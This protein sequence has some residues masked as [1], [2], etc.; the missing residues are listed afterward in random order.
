MVMMRQVLQKFS[1]VI[2]VPVVVVG[3]LGMAIQAQEQKTTD[4]SWSDPEVVGVSGWSIDVGVDTSGNAYVVWGDG[5]TIYFRIRSADGTWHSVEQ[6]ATHSSVLQETAGVNANDA[7][8]APTWVNGLPKV[9]VDSLGQAYVAWITYTPHPD[10]RF[11][12]YFR[13]R[14]AGGTWGPVQQVVGDSVAD[15]TLGGLVVDSSGKAYVTWQSEAGWVAKLRAR[16][17]NGSW[18]DVESIGMGEPVDMVVDASDNV[19]TALNNN[20]AV[21][22]RFRSAAGVWGTLEMV[23]DALFYRTYAIDVDGSGNAYILSTYSDSP[24][25]PGSAYL[26]YRSAGGTWQNILTNPTT[27][28]YSDFALDP[29]GNGYFVCLDDR[30]TTYNYDVYVSYRWQDG[31]WG[32]ESNLSSDSI[33]SACCP[34]ITT[35]VAGD[36]YYLVWDVDQ[37]CF[38]LGS[39]PDPPPPPDLST[40]RKMAVPGGVEP[41]EVVQYIFEVHNAGETTSFV[42]TDTIPIST[43]LVPGSGWYDTGVFTTSVHGITWTA[44]S[45]FETS[46]RAGFSVTVT[47]DS[48]TGTLRIPY[49]ISNVA[50]LSFDTDEH[51]QLTASLVVHPEQAYLPFVIRGS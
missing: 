2:I 25:D 44:T 8:V 40:S 22:Y 46:I 50:G 38:S 27:C 4:A 37:T 13:L 28:L 31:S 33:S 3:L 21:Y 17:S 12:V 45:T 36:L 5:D 43:T 42:L 1:I 47:P 6:V 15:I 7:A 16:A 11:F 49:V 32:P 41:G 9:A 34:D 26:H 19:H 39:K 23:S 35:N 10:R 30:D 48:G 18:G 14:S 29:A 20:G 24:S 51:I